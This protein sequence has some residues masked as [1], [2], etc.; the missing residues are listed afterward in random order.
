MFGIRDRIEEPAFTVEQR[1]DQA[2][3]IRR[4]PPRLAVEARLPGGDGPMTRGR[5]FRILFDY[6][7]GNNTSG[8][9]VAMTAP[10]ESQG[11][12]D[13][14]AIPMTVP[15]ESAGS[16]KGGSTKDGYAMRFF[17]PAS[18]TPETAPQPRDPR[19]TLVEIPEALVAVR[20]FTGLRGGTMVRRQ[21][22]FLHRSLSGTPWA[23]Q[24][25][26]VGWF[27]DPPSTLPFLRRNE[28]AVPVA[29]VEAPV[30]A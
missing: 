25:P 7:A 20:R 3:A 19:V 1:L 21:A 9:R 16:P 15:V 30:A 23:P 12:R 10:V 5:A 11:G 18:F 27:Y 8:D 4:Y 6:I 2:T 22:G 24:G 26:A 17:L 29:R 14:S 13:G 28:V